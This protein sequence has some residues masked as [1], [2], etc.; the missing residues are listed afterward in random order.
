LTVLLLR[1]LVSFR[2][3]SLP[4]PELL[5]AASDRRLPQCPVQFS[6][7]EPDEVPGLDGV[8]VHRELVRVRLHDARPVQPQLQSAVERRDHDP[9]MDVRLD[10]IAQQGRL[11]VLLHDV[12][13]AARPLAPV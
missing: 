5:E 4:R 12:V 11:D 8:L 2:A 13:G 10:V 6:R 9:R 1:R 7:L 3:T